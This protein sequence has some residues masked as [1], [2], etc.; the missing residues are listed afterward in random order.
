MNRRV[1][2]LALGFALLPS[3]SVA[4]RAGDW[5]IERGKSADVVHFTMRYTDGMSRHWQGGDDVPLRTLQ[6]F[7]PRWLETSTSEVR[8]S[9][10]RD[11]GTFQLEGRTSSG[12]GRGEWTFEPD[13]TFDDQLVRRGY[14][15]P[16]ES[17]QFSLAFMDIG[18]AFVDELKSQGYRRPETR[19]L[20]TMANHGVDL[21]YLRGMNKLGYR[22]QDPELLIRM[23]DHGVDPD[24]IAGLAKLGYRDLDPEK[25]VYARDH[26]V[27]A[28]FI[29]A[30]GS[31]LKGLSLSE[32]VWLRDHGVDAEFAA[33]F[34]ELGYR[35][36]DPEELVTL[37]DHGVDPEYARSM[38]EAGFPNL[39]W[40]DLRRARDHGV[41]AHYVRKVRARIKGTLSID[42]V[43]EFRDRGLKL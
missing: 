35:D 4:G 33:G 5:T 43:I 37:R 32:L 34:R 28:D 40:Q 21:G 2:L 13:P 26:G 17:Q 39:P 19:T 12:K 24:Y 9:L 20:V 1:L 14:E 41:D 15:R 42:E 18:L 36:L 11:A 38:A 25:L 3:T 23:R 10:I 16:T 6:G 31:Q 29:E 30:F 7:D 27:D 8:F 22:V